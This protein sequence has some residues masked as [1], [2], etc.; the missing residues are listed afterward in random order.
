MS[1]PEGFIIPSNF[2]AVNMQQSAG[3]VFVGTTSSGQPFRFFTQEEHNKRLSE[4]LGYEK[5]E[6][7]EYVEFVLDSKNK[8]CARI[9]K[10]IFQQHPEILAD[11]SRWKAG[12]E[13]NVTEV[14]DWEVL[15][16]GEMGMLIV[17]GFTTVEQIFA[18]S[19]DKLMMIGTNW[20][21]VKIKA[22]HHIKAKEKQANGHIAVTEMKELK[23]ALAEKDNQIAK[24]MEIANDKLNAVTAP[25]KKAAS[26]L[27]KKPTKVKNANSDS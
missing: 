15:T 16:H 10:N 8:Y 19:D 12:K 20:K 27:K 25:V 22:E 23:D 14:K 24:L 21:D 5:K 18:S 2:S 26:K 1:T 7:I 3:R 9:D 13:S 4:E 11:Y 6:L 17:A